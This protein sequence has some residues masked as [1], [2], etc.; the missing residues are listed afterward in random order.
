MSVLMVLLGSLYPI[1]SI[2]QGA[3]ADK[4]GLRATTIA[5]A[6][7]MGAVLVVARLVRPQLAHALDTEPAPAA[8]T[9]ETAP[10]FADELHAP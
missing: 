6:T 4:I 5:A 7:L 1:G 10:G 9:P 2:V 3:V 8:P